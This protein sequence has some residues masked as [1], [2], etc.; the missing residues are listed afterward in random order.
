MANALVVGGLGFI[1]SHLVDF[2]LDRGD[3]VTIVDDLS[4]NVTPPST[5]SSKCSVIEQDISAI[6]QLDQRF[7]VIYHL[8]GPV[9]PVRILDRAGEIEGLTTAPTLR[10]IELAES[11]QASILYVSSSDVY[12]RAGWLSEDTPAHRY[13]RRTPRA[14]YAEGK[15]RSE[16]LLLRACEEQEICVNIV[17]PFNVAGPR[18]I[19]AAGFVLARFVEAALKG[20]SITVFGDGTQMRSFLHVSEAVRAFVEIAE[21]GTSGEIWNVGNPKNAI[22]IRFLADLVRGQLNPTCTIVHVDP[23]DLFGESFDDGFA[24]LP[25]IGKVNREL[26]WV[27]RAPLSEIIEHVALAV[28]VRRSGTEPRF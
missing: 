6:V 28:E 26:G 7:D 9:G 3:S 1:G 24:K 16:S 10:V 19:P 21:S 22:Q 27:P 14:E 20:D 13:P 4:A 2:L 23:R 11:C 5:Y 12:S 18:Q 17:R 8:A 25:L 15:R